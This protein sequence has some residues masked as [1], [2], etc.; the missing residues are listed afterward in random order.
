MFGGATPAKGG[1]RLDYYAIVAGAIAALH[2]PSAEARQA[3]YE[4]ARRVVLNQLHTPPGRL[5]DDR[6]ARQRR[7][8]E[9][10]IEV[11]EGKS[12]KRRGA[13]AKASAAAPSTRKPAAGS[14]AGQ[15]VLASVIFPAVRFAARGGL[16]ASEA[17]RASAAA[18]AS[19][20]VVAGRVMVRL[21]PS[22]LPT[23]DAAPARIAVLSMAA[24]VIVR[25]RSD[26]L[27]GPWAVD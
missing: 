2:E 20:P 10:A 21:K 17:M 19:A 12:S 27:A 16:Q 11:V 7:A 6:I 26:L 15:A 22:R 13:R 23:S 3:V 9:R 5:S 1:A 25:P 24:L 14:R 18:L 4:H 8:L